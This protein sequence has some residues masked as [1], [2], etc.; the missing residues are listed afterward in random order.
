MINNMTFNHNHQRDAEVVSQLIQLYRYIFPE[1]PGEL[2]K[3][4]VMLDVLKK[5][6][7]AQGEVDK[8]CAGDLRIWIYLHNKE[9]Q[10]F[11]VSV[12]RFLFIY[13]YLQKCVYYHI[14]RIQ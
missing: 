9:G 2:E 14:H 5:Y 1:D 7:K 8:K 4:K 3:E 13:H 12:S 10:S 11:N 6:A